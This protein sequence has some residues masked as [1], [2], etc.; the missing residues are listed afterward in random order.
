MSLRSYSLQVEMEGSTGNSALLNNLEMQLTELEMLQSMFSNPG[1]IRVGDANDLIAIQDFVSGT[2]TEV[3]PFLEITINLH[4]ENAKFELS[5]T[6]PHEYPEIS[7]EVYVRNPK[8]DRQ[9]HSKLNK[10]LTEYLATS[11]K[12]QPCVFSAV[13]WLQDNAGNYMVEQ[14]V[15]E[16]AVNEDQTLARY[17]AIG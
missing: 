16:E 7:P 17:I 12:G 9:R 4:V 15:T 6:Q 11:E 5:V 10:D 2:T 1:E 14:Q 8:L 3:P 13:S